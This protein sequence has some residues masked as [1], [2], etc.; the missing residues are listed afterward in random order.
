[1]IETIGKYCVIQ[2]QCLNTDTMEELWKLVEDI[3]R[4]IE[5]QRDQIDR[6]KAEVLRLRKENSDLQKQMTVFSQNDRCV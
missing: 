6:L 1:M 2:S 5:S 4:I 3:E